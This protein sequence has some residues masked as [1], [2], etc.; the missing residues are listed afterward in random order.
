MPDVQDI[1]E[2]NFFIKIHQEMKKLLEFL[3]VV[4]VNIGAIILNI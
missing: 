2:L 3:A 1:Y 4:I